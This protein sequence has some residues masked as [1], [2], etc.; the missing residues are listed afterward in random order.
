M[1]EDAQ[2]AAADEYDAIHGGAARS[3]LLWRLW[4]R[5]LGDEYPAEVEAYSSCSWWLLGQIV[6]ALRMRPDGLLLDL[7]CG[8]GGPGLWLAR[9]LN[10]RLL[11]IDRSPVAVQLAGERADRF[12]TAGRARFQAGSFERIDLPDSSVDGAV[13]VDALPLSQDR[14]AAL[15]EVRRVLVPGGRLVFTAR[16]PAAGQPSWS[17]LAAGAGL[18]VEQRQPIPELDERWQRLYELWLAH[19]GE[20]RTEL[21]D[22]A[23]DNLLTEAARGIG[24][25]A[26]RQPMLLM[27]R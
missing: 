10:V 9:A 25:R 1:A 14:P 16:E 21:G 5:A 20:L 11:G 12:V 24:P 26:G 13:S 15:R 22:A 6:A 8:R 18:L 27:L 3:P 17:E 2:T 23:A 4:S 7:G 19:A